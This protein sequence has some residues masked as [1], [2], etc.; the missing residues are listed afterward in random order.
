ME[1]NLDPS[2]VPPGFLFLIFLYHH[3]SDMDYQSPL[4]FQLDVYL[5]TDLLE[6]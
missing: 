5:N 6:L 1:F 3:C 2:S 4:N